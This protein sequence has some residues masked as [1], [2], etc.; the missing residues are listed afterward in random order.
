MPGA[1]DA[2]AAFLAAL[3][4]PLLGDELFDA[5][6][7]IVFFVKD[8]AGRYVAVNRTLVTRTGGRGKAALLGRTAQ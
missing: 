7:D 3:G 1:D 4:R 2:R 8:A 6:P 5:V